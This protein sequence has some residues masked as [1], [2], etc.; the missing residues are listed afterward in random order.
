VRKDCGEVRHL[1]NQVRDD[2]LQEYRDDIKF[3]ILKCGRITEYLI[4]LIRY[5]VNHYPQFH[6]SYTSHST[7][8]IVKSGKLQDR[9]A[10][11]GGDKNA[12]INL[13]GRPLRKQ[14][15]GKING[16]GR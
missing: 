13:V 10:I 5:S 16:K 2:V 1:R 14:S 8:G 7:V 6:D 3:W 15:L 9:Y 12:Y 11:W 4:L